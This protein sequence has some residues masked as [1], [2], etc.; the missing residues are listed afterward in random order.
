MRIAPDSS[1]S[2]AGAAG[3]RAATSG[4]PRFGLE[5]S[6]ATDGHWIL[7][8]SSSQRTIVLLR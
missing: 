3:R 6:P 4:S 7:R 1:S 8:I 2:G 5:R